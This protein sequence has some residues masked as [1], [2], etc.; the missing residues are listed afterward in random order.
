MSRV[1]QCLSAIIRQRCPKCWRGAVFSGPIAMNERCPVCD[2]RFQ[3]D[4]GYF[5]GAL[6]M[7]YALSIPLLGLLTLLLHFTLLPSWELQYVVLVALV[8]YL[9]F[10][11][12]VFRYSRILWMFFDLGGEV[13]SSK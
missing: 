4:E 1:F 10:V 11:P 3:Q 7:S 13:R 5:L 9:V 6:Y 2:Y 12:A 8:P